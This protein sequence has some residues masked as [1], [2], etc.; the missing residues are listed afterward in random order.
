MKRP[1]MHHPYNDTFVHTI[2]NT[3]GTA[4]TQWLARL[5]TIIEQCAR[6][7]NL[8]ALTPYTNLTYNYVLAGMMRD[9]PIVLKLRCDHKALEKEVT[10]LHAF[11]NHGCV[12]I[13]EHNKALDALLLERLMPGNSLV[14]LFPH[15]DATATRIASGLLHTLHQ[16]PLPSSTIFPTLEQV[17][18]PFD[19]KP[20]PL[21]PFIAQA[22]K[23]RQQLLST[24]SQQVFLHGD[25]HHDNILSSGERT[26]H[27][28]DP[29]GIIGDPVYDLGVFIRNPLKQLAN[30]S[31]ANTLVYNRMHDCATLLGYDRQRIHDWTYLQTVA[32]A[33]WS[34]EDGLDITHHIR[35]LKTIAPD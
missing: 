2:T 14:S 13:I 32:S 23:L 27:V 9:R 35:F 29:E 3:F 1:L 11:E 28:I 6:Q 16:V 17:I 18:P 24:Q 15:H 12:H 4:G 19:T 31:N 34:L 8:T 30:A 26:W 5:P 21:A 22:R 7:W 20:T 33:Y 10:A 25:F